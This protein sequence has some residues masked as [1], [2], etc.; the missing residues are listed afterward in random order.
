MCIFITLNQTAH[1]VPYGFFYDTPCTK[2]YIRKDGAQPALF[3]IYV[4][5]YVF[6]CVVLCIFCFVT[7]PVLFVCIRVL[8]KCHRVATQ[9][10]LNISY[11]FISSNRLAWPRMRWEGFERTW[12]WLH[13]GTVPEWPEGSCERARSSSVGAAAVRPR[14]ELRTR[15]AEPLGAT[16]YTHKALSFERLVFGYGIPHRRHNFVRLFWLQ[17]RP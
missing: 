10:Q 16:R 3:L 6:L 17:A 13:C 12:T 14:L 7:F 4:F 9:L 8:N 5:F 1:A 15:W 11:H 2:D